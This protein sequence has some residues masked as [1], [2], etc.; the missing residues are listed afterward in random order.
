MEITWGSFF[1]SNVLMKLS[2]ELKELNKYRVL[3]YED[4]RYLLYSQHEN[5]HQF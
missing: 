5:S 1:S 3:I 2:I 4:N